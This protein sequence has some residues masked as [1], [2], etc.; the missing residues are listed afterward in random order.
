[1]RPL[2][3]SYLSDCP[4]KTANE[5]F[6]CKTAKST[7]LPEYYFAEVTF[8]PEKFLPDL[9]FRLEK[10]PLL[11]FALQA[12]QTHSSFQAKIS[13][14]I[15]TWATGR[16]LNFLPQWDG[17]F[18]LKQKLRAL[19]ALFPRRRNEVCSFFF[20]LDAGSMTCELA[21]SPSSDI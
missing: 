2:L 9:E 18:K 16:N 21:D 7:L 19:R 20:D 12:V 3:E 14:K 11:S 13:I 6:L 5:F 1:M 17:L 10:S 4:A 15:L 8:R